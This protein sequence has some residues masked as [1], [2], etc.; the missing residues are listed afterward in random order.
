ME[1]H[2]SDIEEVMIFASLTCRDEINWDY[3]DKDGESVIRKE[4]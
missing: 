1:G 3:Q 2:E 4:H